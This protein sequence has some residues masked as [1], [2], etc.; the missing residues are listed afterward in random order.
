[1]YEKKE[2]DWIL[3][4][5]NNPSFTNTD[6]KTVGLSTKNVSIGSEQMYAQSSVIRENPIFQTDGKFDN[7]KFQQY[8][9]Q[10][11]LAYNNMA[12]DTANQDIAASVS[13]YKD[14]IFAPFENV[15]KNP[16]TLIT[17]TFNPDRVSLGFEGFNQEGTPKWS[18]QELAEMNPIY[19]PKTGQ[20]TDY[21]AEE[22]LFKDFG[23]TAVL[24]TWDFNADVNGNPTNDPV[25]I[26]YQKG[27]YKINPETG[28]YYYEFTDGPTY[29]KEVLSKWNILTKEQSNWNDY[30]FFDSDDR[31][32]SVFGSLMR[33]A[34]M[35]LPLAF[36]PEVTSVY[37]GGSML[38]N[39]T[40]TLA[41]LSKMAI[42]D[43]KNETLSQIENFVKSTKFTTSEYAKQHTWSTENILNLTGSTFEFLY[44]MKWMAQ[45]LPKIFGKKAIPTTEAEKK[46]WL[47]AKENELSNNLTTLQAQLPAQLGRIDEALGEKVMTMEMLRGAI[48]QEAANQLDLLAKNYHEFGEAISRMY[49]AITFGT[50]T[51][52]EAK[53]QG[54]SDEAATA[55]TLGSIA[56]QYA[57]LKSHIGNW[58]F[59][60]KLDKFKRQKMI[61][62]LYAGKDQAVMQSSNSVAENTAFFQKWF[63]EGK[64]LAV[65]LYKPS[66][67]ATQ[68][69]VQGMLAGGIEMTSFEVLRDLTA[70]VYNL[71][72]KIAGTDGHMSAFGDGN[73]SEL[74]DR[75]GS[76]FLGGALGGALGQVIG[77]NKFINWKQ[78][79]DINK[80]TYSEAWQNYIYLSREGKTKDVID[81]I[82]KMKVTSSELSEHESKILSDGSKVYSQGSPK[83]NLDIQWKDQLIEQLTKIDQILAQNNLK[84]S[85]E[86]LIDN[87][88]KTFKFIR[89]SNS[90]VRSAFV[91]DFNTAVSK[92][93]EADKAL[94]EFEKT[95]TKKEEGRTDKEERENPET[96][97]QRRSK[98]QSDLK[99]AKD[100]VNKFLDGTYSKDYILAASY[101]MS[102]LVSDPYAKLQFNA[103]ALGK[104]GVQNIKDIA[105]ARLEELEREYKNAKWS[106]IILYTHKVF[107]TINEQLINGQLKGDVNRISSDLQGVLVN[108]RQY[109]YDLSSRKDLENNINLLNTDL[110]VMQALLT[111]EASRESGTDMPVHEFLAKW[112]NGQLT[113]TESMLFLFGNNFENRWKVILENEYLPEAIKRPLLKFIQSLEDYYNP[114][115]MSEEQY[116]SRIYDIE[117]EPLFQNNELQNLAKLKEEVLNKPTTAVQ[118]T[119]F[120]IAQKVFGIDANYV[121]NTAENI[122]IRAQSI[123][124]IS[125]NVDFIDQLQKIELATKLYRSS[126]IASV[127]QDVNI[128][129]A[130]GYNQIK[131]DLYGTKLFTTDPIDANNLLKEVYT[132]QNQTALYK[133]VFI[134][135]ENRKQATHEKVGQQFSIAF[136][137]KLSNLISKI[138][139]G[140]NKD[141]LT[142]ALDNAEK[143][144]LLTNDNVSLAEEDK[145]AFEKEVLDVQ[146][147]IFDFFQD[148]LDKV[149]DPTELSK[150]INSDNF[151]KGAVKEVLTGN[152]QANI[153]D[154]TLIG[155]LATYA[156]V[157]AKS[158][159]YI[160]KQ[161]LQSLKG[162]E[163]A[164]LPLRTQEIAAQMALSYIL[165]PKVFKMFTKAYN[166][167]LGHTKEHTQERFMF[168][169][170]FVLIDAIAGAGKSQA[171]MPLAIKGALLV[172]PE[173]A[174]KIA[175]IHINKENADKQLAD[176]EL[177]GKGY[178]IESFMKEHFVDYD[179]VRNSSN[180][181]IETVP[182]RY[183]YDDSDI[184]R[185]NLD[186]KE[187]NEPPTLLIIDEVARLSSEDCDLLEKLEEKYDVRLVIAGDLYQTG[188]I[189]NKFKV[190]VA[191]DNI[192]VV[193]T[194]TI[195]SFIGT[196]RNGISFRNLNNL[197][198]FNLNI[199]SQNCDNF[200][201]TEKIASDQD[202]ASDNVVSIQLKYHFTDQ[203]EIIG[204][205]IDTYNDSNSDRRNQEITQAIMYALQNGKSIG[206]IYYSEDSPIY[207]YIANSLSKELSDYILKNKRKGA[208]AQGGELDY[209]IVDFLNAPFENSSDFARGMYTS[210]TRSKQGT[211]LYL[212]GVDGTFK[213]SIDD[214][215]ITY[216]KSIPKDI[217]NKQIDNYIELLDKLD[218]NKTMRM[219]GV[220]SEKAIEISLPD[221]FDGEIGDVKKKQEQLTS[222]NVA[223][224][225]KIE[226]QPEIQ[227]TSTESSE[228]AHKR[229]TE[230]A[231]ISIYTLMTNGVGGK[232][233]TDPNTGKDR[234][235]LDDTPIPGTSNQAWQYR[236][237]GA[238]GIKHMA[239]RFG[240]T[241]I[242]PLDAD[243][244]WSIIDGIKNA[245]EL[246]N[247]KQQLI[248]EVTQILNYIDSTKRNGLNLQDVYAT[249][250]FVGR[251]NARQRPLQENTLNG[252]K[253]G[254]VSHV[255]AKFIKN[256]LENLY[257]IFR[258]KPGDRGQERIQDLLTEIR[259]IIGTKSTGDLLEVPIFKL[260]NPQTYS[261][262]I[263]EQ[264]RE[265]KR[266]MPNGFRVIVDHI[267][268]MI[269]KN[270]KIDDM[271]DY[272]YTNVLQVYNNGTP[273]ASEL[274]TYAKL[275]SIFTIANN[276]AIPIRLNNGN[277]VPRDSFTF[278]G[279]RQSLS[280]AEQYS[281]DE[282]GKNLGFDPFWVEISN[283]AQNS[284]VKLSNI[285]VAAP[286]DIQLPNGQVIEKGYP[287]VI[288]GD[289]K[290]YDDRTMID[291]LFDTDPNR[292]VN[293]MYVQKPLASL[294]DYV[295]W[296]YNSRTEG[297]EKMN[298]VGS[299]FTA[300][301]MF[302]SMS[303]EIKTQLG[304]DP[305]INS[306][307]DK[308]LEITENVNRIEESA[309]LLTGSDKKA[310]LNEA[311][312]ILTADSS[313]E[314]HT[315]IS[316][317]KKI[318]IWGVFDSFLYDF[319]FRGKKVQSLEELPKE[320]YVKWFIETLR[321][322]GM[323]DSYWETKLESTKTA[324]KYKGISYIQ[325]VDRN[326]TPYEMTLWNGTKVPFM[327]LGKYDSTTGFGNVTPIL[328][329]I[330]QQIERYLY[331]ESGSRI[332]RFAKGV[333][334][335][336]NRYVDNRSELP[337]KVPSRFTNPDLE[338]KYGS[339]D[340]EQN[341]NNDPNILWFKDLENGLYHVFKAKDGE[342]GELTITDVSN[343]RYIKLKSENSGD[344]YF[345]SKIDDLSLNI[346]QNELYKSEDIEYEAPITIVNQESVDLTSDENQS[347]ITNF[348]TT[349]WEIKPDGKTLEEILGLTPLRMS[350]TDFRTILQGNDDPRYQDMLALV[351]KVLNADSS[352]TT[353]ER[354]D[355]YKD[356][357]CSFSIRM[358]L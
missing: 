316:P 311:A 108:L 301:R 98:L 261:T 34:V 53:A 230:I 255:F 19:D 203:G 242:D 281:W 80:M 344:E 27:Q 180:G 325:N 258:S 209:Y 128:K 74:L 146:E 237:D 327:M 276:I 199:L 268:D 145:I 125:S 130:F 350:L 195:N 207:Q 273:V 44:S 348:G 147:A 218:L 99:T 172:K 190:P 254:K 314:G 134:A 78:A 106:D 41:T 277:W 142:Q 28:T 55:L 196:P 345:Y 129:N 289:S 211:L 151:A 141:K 317:D 324:Q 185:Y 52:G 91:Q 113:T 201:H 38:L 356:T 87:L 183:V 338:Q 63:N 160:I 243:F 320:Q 347:V 159:K 88:V 233:V 23:R 171:I 117:Y 20:F 305:K 256:K 278:L 286:H 282:L 178:D 187:T 263:L 154:R 140:W 226:N 182:T 228:Y 294:E 148:N 296:L 14:N 169:H 318:Q 133:Q 328:N 240:L 299:L 136:Y 66:Q 67:M 300:F 341:L 65:S 175:A 61:E 210:L 332:W 313:I 25:E 139:D 339:G 131:N 231:E 272:L 216:S 170:P 189:S 68:A 10:R 13:F 275:F 4:S 315:N 164:I 135:I 257:K 39:F 309:K 321:A 265:G 173:L 271:N 43:S 118:K 15:R 343:K 96:I 26:Y 103:Y 298:K 306:L 222:R 93:V 232:V 48:P 162:T 177:P 250:A 110:N 12:M 326:T 308:L 150:F 37:L 30:D 335:F 71:A 75:Y 9:D 302:Q 331:P 121:F 115:L 248:E 246:A 220:T 123:D 337:Q 333:D 86:Q 114:E 244:V 184:L 247:D 206:L 49:M 355:N 264:V 288:V 47:T 32:K 109:Y 35:L 352:T 111:P 291:A 89:L 284:R 127:K 82:R 224:P 253:N 319:L 186:I 221:G 217:I 238:N 56:G 77:E 259:L 104:E 329:D 283:F 100:N 163:F 293:F 158:S 18:P 249:F 322:K 22:S 116:N 51:Y 188:A 36:G 155:M 229:S 262:M 167:T 1:M 235:V 81:G 94:Q 126:L 290:F 132:L 101:E 79:E 95:S 153:D 191:A 8:Y 105:P 205:K 17:E 69:T 143:L 340:I 16:D 57:L 239:D 31:K 176:L 303:S 310:K 336:N 45:Q 149:K 156:A 84:V 85:D 119:V 215:N 70:S 267:E 251:E 223:E 3:E 72:N 212:Q 213:Q 76:T 33:N 252:I 138:P 6:F 40:S 297:A 219:F 165:N 198:D 353:S 174:N 200:M 83:D 285:M 357:I 46:A 245:A 73:F 260:M 346:E 11:L 351:D 208:S 280:K 358:K 59:P 50:E 168:I 349:G 124:E 62:T 342:S 157:S 194:N 304:N 42:G 279:P 330:L 354:L 179:I 161:I 120:D 334:N 202:F 307:Y 54:A 152:N 204:D 7:D 241:G 323:K 295:S 64:N 60:S 234:I 214:P 107:D 274:L 24:A 137:K 92:V 192:D 266:S 5:I 112:S 292:R 90:K 166:L 312:N 197:K 97:Q 181:K 58:I 227:K 2:H 287:F 270:A 225:K 236:R 29:D 193:S 144:K 269:K 102:E 122:I 21:T